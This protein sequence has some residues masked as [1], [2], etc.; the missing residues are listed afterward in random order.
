MF[1]PKL[2]T[3][4][5]N[6]PHKWVI[7]LIIF[8]VFLD[9]SSLCL[10]NSKLLKWTTYSASLDFLRGAMTVYWKKFWQKFPCGTH[11]T[12]VKRGVLGCTESKFYYVGQKRGIFCH[13]PKCFT[14]FF[15]K[16]STTICCSWQEQLL[17]VK[18]SCRK[19]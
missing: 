18:N 5:P 3:L 16:N 10:K 17:L 4:T 14:N 19:K 7:S 13:C 1:Q 2:N 11:F 9:F 6:R 12:F 15:L 8:I